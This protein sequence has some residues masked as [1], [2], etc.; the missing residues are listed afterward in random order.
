MLASWYRYV[1]DDSGAET[2]GMIPTGL[3]TCVGIR[4]SMVFRQSKKQAQPQPRF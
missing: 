2:Q 1:S 4:T 3:V